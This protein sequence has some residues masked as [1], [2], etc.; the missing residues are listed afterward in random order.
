MTKTTG[1]RIFCISMVFVILFS[2][3]AFPS[4]AKTKE[5]LQ[6]EIDRLENQIDSN[7]GKIENSREN[8]EEL[9][10]QISVMQEQL[11]LY[12]SQLTD[13][14]KQIAEKDAVINTYQ[15]EIDRLQSEIDNAVSQIEQQ[16]AQIK[17][18]QDIL[19]ERMRS[20]YMAGE[21]STL[22]VLLSAE[23]YETFLTRLELMKRVS[24]HDNALVA[25]LQ[26]E[27]NALNAAKEQ[28]LQNQND[29]QEKQSAIE[30]E[31]AS[32]NASRLEVQTLYDTLN[33]KQTSMES[34]VKSLNNLIA[35][36]DKN[37][38]AY[39]NAI[40]ARQK[41]MDEYDDKKTADMET[42]TGGKIP[43]VKPLQYSDAY[44]SQHYG[45]NGHKG[46]DLCTRGTGSTQGKEIRAAAD[47][48]VSTA[49]YHSSWGNNVYINHGNGIYTRYAHCSRM[50]VSAGQRVSA[51]QVIAYVGNT[52]NSFGPHLHF[53]VY[54]NK[55]RVNPENWIPRYP[56]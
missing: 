12:N 16:A 38:A 22:E 35:Q 10:K 28:M 2:L 23:D 44:V 37:S 6:A 17:A 29:Q 42:G 56:D 8:I 27:I 20:A 21:T 32:I 48:V 4:S 51:G 31:R 52:G 33:K 14:N 24:E 40:A 25:G 15:A 9:Q 19:K 36:L 1:K 54:V 11:N 55:T 18:T 34:Q 30:T 39:Q 7:N 53:E 45:H 41:E 46:V 49:E 13:L 3:L 50:I 5:E 43:M 26:E 47:G